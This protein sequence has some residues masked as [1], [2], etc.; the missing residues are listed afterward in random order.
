MALQGL[1]IKGK[2][3]RYDW[4]NPFDKIAFYASR[5]AQLHN[6]SINL[7]NSLTQV[8]KA[9]QNPVWT[10]QARERLKQIKLLTQVAAVQT[11]LIN[12]QSPC[13]ISLLKGY[14]ATQHSNV[15]LQ[16]GSN[17]QLFIKNYPAFQ[18][19]NL[20]QFKS[21]HCKLKQCNLG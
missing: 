3:V 9:F 18:W 10:E 15:K 14:S 16:G 6:P 19:N 2:K 17:S 13:L 8:I 20:I 12:Q 11:F 7:T 4:I 1:E 5:Q 21:M